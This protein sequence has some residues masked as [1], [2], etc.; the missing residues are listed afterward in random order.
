VASN[1][2]RGPQGHLGVAAAHARRQFYLVGNGDA[3]G[4]DQHM[5]G[6]KFAVERVHGFG[7]GRGHF[8]A[9]AAAADILDPHAAFFHDLAV[10]RYFADLVD[11]QG[12]L[13]LP[14]SRQL[15]GEL[16]HQGRFSAA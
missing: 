16:E 4:F 13:A 15:F 3:G 8:T 9:N 6:T 10:D 12:D 2:H 7:E 11:Q 5:I 14:V 1:N